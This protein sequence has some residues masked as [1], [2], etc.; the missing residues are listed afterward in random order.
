[1][2]GSLPSLDEYARSSGSF[3]DSALAR[4]CVADDHA[5]KPHAPRAHVAGRDA[6]LQEVDLPACRAWAQLEILA[7]T[8]HADL[9]KNSILQD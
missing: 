6:N 3:G 4:V 8:A 1:M 2:R 5:V 9:R 7:D